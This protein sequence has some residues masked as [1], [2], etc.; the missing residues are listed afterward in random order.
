MPK[1]CLF[2]PSISIFVDAVVV[3]GEGETSDIEDLRSVLKKFT[4][5]TERETRS[6]RSRGD[7]ATD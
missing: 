7:V 5:L 3:T 4:P 2:P 1:F 6:E